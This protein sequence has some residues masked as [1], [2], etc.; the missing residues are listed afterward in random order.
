VGG[1]LIGELK[2]GEVNHNTVRKCVK[3]MHMPEGT[4]HRETFPPQREMDTTSILLLKFDQSQK[5]HILKITH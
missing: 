4:Y 1:Q 5:R 2:L 3:I